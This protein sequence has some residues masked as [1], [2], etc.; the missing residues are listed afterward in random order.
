MIRE[1]L[2]QQ[3]REDTAAKKLAEIKTPKPPLMTRIV[4]EL[5]HYY[6]G[7]R[8]LALETRISTRYLW[9][10][11]TGHSL[12][13]KERQ[14][15]VRTA[16][17]LFRLVPFSIFI[18]V[19]FMEFTLPIFLKLFPNM[20][21]STFQEESKEREK[22]KRRLKVKLEVARFL[23]DTI[24]EIGL[25][26]KSKGMVESK[27]AE[28]AA[29][30]KK[31]RSQGGYVTTEELF[32]FSKLFEDELTLDNLGMGALRALCKLLDITP[33]GS[34]EILRFQLNLKLRELKADDKEIALEGGVEALTISE[35]QQACRA[36]GMR[37]L[38]MSEQR[39]RNQMKQWLELSLNDKVPPS[40]L[41]LSRT[42]YLSENIAFTDQLK[43]LISLVPESVAEQ[44]KQRLVELEGNKVGYKE[45]LDL[46]K[47]IEKAIAQEREAVEEEKRKREA[48]EKAKK[49]AVLLAAKDAESSKQILIESFPSTP[50]VLQTASTVATTALKESTET[51][52]VDEK[53]L[54]SIE[55]VIHGSVVSE[56]KHDIT[57][58]KEKLQEHAEDLIEVDALEKD[59][60]EPVGAKRL[61]KR[62]TS[63]IESLDALVEKLEQ[64]RKDINETVA[65]PAVE[66]AVTRK[67]FPRCLVVIIFQAIE[68]LSK[69]KDI[70]ISVVQMKKLV[71]MLRKEEEMDALEAFITG[72][73]PYPPVLPENSNSDSPTITDKNLSSSN[74]SKDGKSLEK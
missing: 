56:A 41:L 46:I 29:F 37:S 12:M 19:P 17:D 16:S 57:E 32:K 8:L 22:L 9:R 4:D 53:D 20:L 73:S 44:V 60:K 31:V 36:R 67:K 6:H 7:F 35:L 55:D 38:G 64:Q 54:K 2:Q 30:I 40:L 66:E 26:R 3:E 71:E 13:R 33:L 69:H 15:L 23:Q 45:R 52:M 5:K 47:N 61:R 58:L 21:P 18:I 27:A 70:E 72:I 10:L 42:L 43:A 51:A 50:P 34:P 68:L 14:Q 63:I 28:F 65:D 48:E 39:L 49:D 25:E 1:D 11:V 74:S 24:D 59:L 62:V